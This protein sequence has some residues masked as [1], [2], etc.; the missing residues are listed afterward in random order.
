MSTDTRPLAGQIALMRRC[1]LEEDAFDYVMECATIYADKVRETG[2]APLPA[3][4]VSLTT[5]ALLIAS[6]QDPNKTN[7]RVYV[8]ARELLADNMSDLLAVA[9]EFTQRHCPTFG[10]G[11]E[12]V[13]SEAWQ[14]RVAG[15]EAPA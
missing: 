6:T 13:M 11:G 15:P 8:E 2:M 3:M 1:G 9:I 7:E 12:D 4:L 14:Q 10:A 5:F